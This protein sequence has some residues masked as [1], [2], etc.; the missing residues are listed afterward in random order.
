[1]GQTAG[2]YG[3]DPEIQAPGALLMVTDAAYLPVTWESQLKKTLLS[4]ITCWLC[5]TSP[6]PV[7]KHYVFTTTEVHTPHVVCGQQTNNSLN[8]KHLRKQ[9]ELSVSK[10]TFMVPINHLSVG[11]HKQTDARD[12]KQGTQYSPY[13]TTSRCNYNPVTSRQPR[14]HT[15]QEKQECR[16]PKKAQHSRRHLFVHFSHL[17]VSQINTD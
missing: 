1:M 5:F 17:K 16:V 15:S 11:A 2:G 10:H 12:R 6:V 13:W 3:S 9:E 8:Q 7:W 4:F 14:N